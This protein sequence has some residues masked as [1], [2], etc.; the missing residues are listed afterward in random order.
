MHRRQFL[1]QASASGILALASIPGWAG[2]TAT[3]ATAW[4]DQEKESFLLTAQ[5]TKLKGIKTGTTG[6]RRAT[7]SNGQLTHDAHVQTIDE[8]KNRFTTASGTEHNFRDSYKFNIAAYRLDRLVGLNMAPVS[9]ERKIQG[10]RGALTWWVDD[11]QMMELERHN[12]KI[13]PPNRANWNDQMCNVRLFNELV[14]NNDPN[15]GN[16]LITNDWRLWM[17]DFSRGFRRSKKLRSP[18]N[19]TRIDGRVYDGLRALDRG[20]LDRE[21]SS[22]LLKTEIE[23]I[24]AR[25]D[26]ILAVFDRHIAKRGE[27][28]VICR[29]PGH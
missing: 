14:Y 27:S 11:V 2:E 19:L 28:L 6:T 13:A 23:G 5:L 21:L 1:Y 20:A 4:S 16:F 8:Q 29:R 24:L 7:L 22:L 25:R 15:L 3:P 12:K 10:E 26:H 17:V 18:E 9:V